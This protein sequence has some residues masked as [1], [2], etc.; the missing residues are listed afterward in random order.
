M[1]I[2]RRILRTFAI[3]GAA[4]FLTDLT[5]W[6]G[7][8]GSQGEREID[9]FTYEGRSAAIV[10]CTPRLSRYHK[11]Y[12][13]IDGIRINTNQ[14]VGDDGRTRSLHLL[15]ARYSVK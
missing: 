13:S 4:L 9:R 6:L 2:P 5:S 14:L 11:Y 1:N 8:F 3:A 7:V 12:L 10:D 15:G